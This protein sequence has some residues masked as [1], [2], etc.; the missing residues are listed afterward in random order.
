MPVLPV[1]AL[2]TSPAKNPELIDTLAEASVALPRSETAIVGDAN[3]AAPPCVKVT[4]LP[5][6][7]IT[8]VLTCTLSDSEG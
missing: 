6:P 7:L 5:A 8:G 3:T 1:T 4:A 2:S